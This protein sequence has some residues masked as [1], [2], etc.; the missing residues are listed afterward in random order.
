VLPGIRSITWRPDAPAT[1]VLVEA[2]D[3]GDPLK[4]VP[5][6]DQVSLLTAPFD[7]EP[8][9]FAETELRY[10]GI[11]W[12]F[13][14]L[15][16]VSER[17]ARTTRTRTW[18]VNPSNLAEPPRLLWDRSSEDRYS[19]P[20]TPVLTDHPTELRQ[21]P[22]RSADGRWLYLRGAGAAKEGARPFLDRL[23]LTTLKTERL[24]Q[25][26][27]PH[28]ENLLEVLDSEAK[29]MVFSRESPTERPNLWLRELPGGDAKQLTD[30]PD[31]APWF[32]RVKAELVRY[33]RPDGI[34]LNATLYLPPG[35]DRERDGALPFFFWAYPREFLTEQGASQLSGSPL[36]FKRPAR[37]DHLLLLALG[38]GVLDNPTMPIVGKD[39][40]EPNDSYVEQLVAN[41][42]AAIDHL[43]ERGVADRDRIGIGGHSYGAFM[44]AN[45][46]AHS[47]LFRAGIARSGA[48]NRTLTPFGFQ[49]EPRTYW[50]A[51]ETYHEMS[52][53]T[54]APKVNEPILLIHGMRDSNS[55]TFPVQ[56][57][58][59]FAALK[60]NGGNV[61]Y[62]QLPLEDHG[63]GARES[64]RHVLWEMIT[65]LDEYVKKPATPS[66]APVT[67][68]TEAEPFRLAVSKTFTGKNPAILGV[69]HGREA[70]F[71][72]VTVAIR[73]AEAM[74]RD[75]PLIPPGNLDDGMMARA[76]DRAALAENRI[77]RRLREGPERR[78]TRRVSHRVTRV[79]RV[80]LGPGEIVFPVALVDER[81]FVV[82]GRRQVAHV[83]QV[84]RD[85]VVVQLHRLATTL[86][87]V[88]I[89]RPV[90]IHIHHRINRLH[91][92]KIGLRHER[93]AER[94]F[95]R[96]GGFVRDRHA[97]VLLRA[98]V[99]IVF[100]VL[101][102]D[103][104]RP[105][106]EGRPRQVTRQIE[107]DAL[108][109][110]VHQIA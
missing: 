13:P 84:E 53:F 108:V 103:G 43:V 109:L 36:E 94:I 77:I 71:A 65:W 41:A 82:A 92:R 22:L 28:Y 59:M 96:A 57:E 46:L 47:D 99:V 9:I 49:A 62:V 20:G 79:A 29:R 44:T 26:S 50:Q 91:P 105:C 93:L 2:L 90:V 67:G 35:Y 17:S 23:D 42:R 45:L 106:V 110:P 58:R 87:P 88:E 3:E 5:K 37:Q 80:E 102:G 74:I 7:G 15:A 32:A 10:G 98:V 64:R 89:G 34:Q 39:G 11:L 69:T 14:E 61:R 66:A 97:D 40:R 55:G 1:L 38:Y 48:Y 76:L 81:S 83:G 73:D 52:P 100:S 70:G 31:P 54:H 4:E 24:W 104:R 27:P 72:V 78:V 68:A 101:R 6:R 12:A 56:S 107:D 63:Y 8:V 95:E 85:H 33:Q 16:F 18:V 60:G 75:H 86:A 51:A 19:D 21:V 25:S 30:L